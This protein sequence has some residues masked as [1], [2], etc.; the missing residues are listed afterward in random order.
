MGRIICISGAKGGTGKT[1][2]CA[3]LAAALSRLNQS[4]IAI[5]GNLSTS[6]LGIHLGIPRYPVT[7][8][9]V[10][11][12]R[13]RIKDALYYH[14]AGFR[15]IPADVSLSS[16]INP[17]S[18]ELMRLFYKLTNDT[19]FI[20]VDSAA[21]LGQESLSALEASDEV[22]TVT[23]PELPA[24]ADALKLKKFAERFGTVNLGVVVNRVKGERQE[25]SLGDIEEFLGLPLIGMVHEDRNV[26]RAISYREPVVMY[27]PNSM[28]SREIKAVAA[29]LMG[30][31]VEVRPSVFQRVFS[32]LR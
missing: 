9:T 24:L 13:G 10:L 29:H 6:N 4:V 16:M 5:D 28:A 30:E 25:F 11:R 18:K 32:F 12:G 19:D 2:V 7:L 14:P 26:R 8:Q 22:I 17:K 21:G 31:R 1:T 20:L 3:N 27:S 15:I 23:N